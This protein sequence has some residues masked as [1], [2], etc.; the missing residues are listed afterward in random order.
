MTLSSKY[1][2]CLSLLICSFLL[3]CTSEQPTTTTTSS[4][5]VE[6]FHQQI[7]ATLPFDDTRDFE[8]V[9]KGFI[10]TRKDPVIKNPDGSVAMDLSWF[11]FLKEDAPA[12]VNPSLWRQS[13][14]NSKHEFRRYRNEFTA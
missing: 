13:Q 8:R 9:D 7:L 4:Q 12:T 1:A 3:S 11:D 14:L 5:S 6:T 2:F 10:A